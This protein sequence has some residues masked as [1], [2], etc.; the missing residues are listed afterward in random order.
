MKH[1]LARWMPLALL[2]LSLSVPVCAADADVAWGDVYCFSGS[3]IAQ[4]NDCQGIIITA[5]PEDQLGRVYLGS[6]T[7]AAG[8]VLTQTQAQQLTLIP[9]QGAEG[10]AIVG[11]MSIT[12][13]GL[14]GE[15]QMTIRI[16]SGKNEAPT[17]ED[18]EFETYK[19][20]P[21]EVPLKISDPENDSLTVTVIKEPKRGTLEIA[22]D[23]TVT[24]TPENNKVGKDSFTYTVA[25]SAG[26]ISEEATVRI[27]ILRPSDR[28]TYQDMDGDPAQLS[29]VWM[30]ESGLY[31]GKTVAGEKLFCPND[32]VTRGE[33]IAM[34]VRLT[35]EDPQLLETGFID[36]S[37]MPLWLQP[38]VS[39]AV[40]CGFISGYPTENGLAMQAD[41]AIIGSEA[42]VILTRM[43]NLTT[44][45]TQPV[46]A[47]FDTLP[48]WAADACTAASQAGLMTVTAPE[49]DLTYRD[50]ALMLYRANLLA[51]QQEN[52]LLAWA[53]E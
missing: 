27:R 46:M 32:T 34:C 37:D 8:D 25:D 12:P 42:A 20:I 28:E 48:A 33:F 45:G 21:G 9:V 5:V 4:E 51:G 44:D 2:V 18:S 35:G 23:G 24:Y 3:T 39:T 31:D 6:R 1:L 30:R 22:E 38:Y 52:S 41:T 16:G 11:C 19:N 49:G 14:S 13:E 43:L 50:A 29:A 7:I 53:K 10:D 26:N 40:K 15:S 36:G 17:A 47:E